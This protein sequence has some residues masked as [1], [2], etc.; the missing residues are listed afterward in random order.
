MKQIL[1]SILVLFISASTSNAQ[2]FAKTARTAV[3]YL[4]NN[5]ALIGCRATVH[6]SIQEQ[7]RKRNTQILTGQRLTSPCVLNSLRITKADTISAKT[8][9]SVVYRLQAMTKL[10]NEIL[11]SDSTHRII[12]PT[13]KSTSVVHKDNKK[14]D[15]E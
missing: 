9:A 5:K 10:K 6:Y 11:R 3:K 7:Q 15:Y 1:I 8:S 14:N 13:L 4:S 2:G 12:L